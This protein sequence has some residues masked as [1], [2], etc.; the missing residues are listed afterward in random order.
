VLANSARNA[1]RYL[2]GKA[3]PNN[4]GVVS[5]TS[6]VRTE[7]QNL[8]VYGNAMGTGSAKL[9]A[10]STSHVT[11]TDEGAGDVSVTM[12][13]PYQPMF[14]AQMPTVGLSS[15]PSNLSFNMRIV[16]QMRAI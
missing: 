8:A 6:A 7:T 5:I 2:A 16:V 3:I 10:L 15:P 4:T 13:Y 9:P 11:V 12:L 1:A 14:G